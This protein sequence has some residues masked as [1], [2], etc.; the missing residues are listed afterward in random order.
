MVRMTPASPGRIEAL[1]G[2]QLYYEVH[3]SGEPLLL[4][5]GFMGAS[6]DW[7]GL[8]SECSAH[9]QLIVPDLRGSR[10]IQ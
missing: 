10:P 6:S 3:G 2:I 1:N 4:L 5:H 9:F 8:V 7:E